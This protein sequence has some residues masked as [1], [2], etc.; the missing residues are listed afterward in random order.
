MRLQTK[1]IASLDETSVH[2]L[3]V[4][5]AAGTRLASDGDV[6]SRAISNALV[7]N[8]LETP[9]FRVGVYVELWSS[10]QCL[11]AVAGHAKVEVNG[12][13]CGTWRALPI[14]AGGEVR[15]LADEGEAY[16]AFSGLSG[17]LGPVE[18]GERFYVKPVEDFGADLSARYVPPT[19]LN[20]YFNGGARDVLLEKILRHL[21]LACE[22]AKRGAKLVRVKVGGKIFDVWVEE[23][24]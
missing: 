21:R 5:D 19:L 2:G 10:V 13:K 7:G 6:F 12:V 18:P 9:V 3:T 15:V 22:M 17:Q 20:E 4:I 1:T 23:V 8:S 14:P 11:A 16:L 24:R